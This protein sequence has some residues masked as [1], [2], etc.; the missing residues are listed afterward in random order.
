MALSSRDINPCNVM[1]ADGDVSVVAGADA[2][3]SETMPEDGGVSRDGRMDI[4]FLESRSPGRRHDA[5]LPLHTERDVSGPTAGRG[6]V[7]GG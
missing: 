5:S 7:D 1:T 3:V 2:G 6:V 4:L